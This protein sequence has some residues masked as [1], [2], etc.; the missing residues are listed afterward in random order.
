MRFGI[1]GATG[2]VVDAAVLELLMRTAPLGPFIARAVALVTAI[3]ATWLLN[4]NFTFGAS[5]H[6]LLGEGVRYGS[7][8]LTSAALNYLVYSAL[9]IAFTSLQPLE[10]MVLSSVSAM[11]FSFFAYSRFVFRR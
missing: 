11:A 1:V 7:V 6:S 3:G 9:L 8:G 5:R 4:R 2:F 10:A